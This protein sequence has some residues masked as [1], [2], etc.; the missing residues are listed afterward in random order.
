MH[1]PPAH[2]LSPHG[3]AGFERPYNA[4]LLAA[5]CVTLVLLAKVGWPLIE[6]LP[7]LA[8]ALLLAVSIVVA[9]LPS[10]LCAAAVAT[11]S[12]HWERC[13]LGLLCGA[14]ALAPSLVCSCMALRH[15]EEALL[16][17]LL[18]LPASMLLCPIAL[19]ASLLPGSPNTG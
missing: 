17:A 15:G 18:Y 1:D 16:A 3:P 12:G 14:V 9:F 6:E 8:S 13:L 10:A 2:H 7:M 11:R 5:P 4:T 19:I